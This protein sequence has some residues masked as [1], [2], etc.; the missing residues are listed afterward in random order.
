MSATRAIRS[1]L[2][3][4]VLLSLL[5]VACGPAA[6]PT[7]MPTPTRPLRPTFTPTPQPTDTPTPEPPTPTP[8]PTD[9][10]TEPPTATPEPPTPT[11]EAKPV[12]VVSG[13]AQVNVRSGPG[14][15][16]PQLG[17]VARGAELEIVG[18]N[19]AGDWW[20]VC[21]V[22]GQPAWIVARL[23]TV[24][25]AEAVPVAANIPPPP[26]QPTRP[27][28]PRPAPTQPPA[29]QPTPQPAFRFAKYQLEP[30]PNSN[31]IVTV[32]GGLYN[33]TLD[34]SKPI[35]GYKLVVQAPWGERK[36][37]EFG[38]VFLRGDPGLPGEFLYN[39]KIEF[40]VADGTYRA[41]VADP[42]GNQVAEAWD[43]AVSGETRTFLAR[44]KEP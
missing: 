18:R 6:E 27:P 23:V 15:A 19:A 33:R 28:A 9:T 29:P 2:S 1:T 3:I 36:E 8:Q 43:L 16:Y 25:N 7:P 5:L 13:S 24:R 4:A 41:W 21:C 44:W 37:V 39:A 31:P 30:R 38:E 14:T 40:A 26:V 34:L 22:N 42:G 12:A 10:P 11:P 32:F 35:T 17:S 20:Q